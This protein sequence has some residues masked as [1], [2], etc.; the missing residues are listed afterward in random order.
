MTRRTASI[1]GFPVYLRIL[2]LVLTLAWLPAGAQ[3]LAMDPGFAT[4]V[5]PAN[6]TRSIVS[7]PDYTGPASGYHAYGPTAGTF[8]SSGNLYFMDHGTIH[9]IAS[10]ND[11]IPVLSNSGQPNYVASPVA[12]YIYEVGG[13]GTNDPTVGAGCTVTGNAIGN[14]CYATLAW[15]GNGPGAL[16]VDSRGNVFVA[17]QDDTEIRVIYA[18]GTIPNLPANPIV[19]M[20]YAIAGNGTTGNAGDAGPGLSAELKEPV[21]LTLDTSNNVYIA[22]AAANAIRVLY[23]GQGNVIGLPSSPQAGYL[24]TIVGQLGSGCTNSGANGPDDCG[25]YGPANQALLSDPQ[26]VHLDPSGNLYISD[27]EDHRLRAVY[28]GGNLP[29]VSNP[30]AGSIYTVA[31]T[32]SY[33]S[34]V[35]VEGS[36]AS[37]TA[38]LPLAVTID[39]AGNIYFAEQSTQTIQRIDANGIINLAMGGAQLNNPSPVFCSGTTDNLGDGCPSSQVFFESMAGV[40]LDP[41]GNLYGNDN[42]G[43]AMHKSSLSATSLNFTESVGFTTSQTMTLYNNGAQPL[44]FSGLTVSPDFAQVPT[45]S[46]DCGGSTM[47]A[48]ATSCTVQIGYTAP[49]AGTNTGTLAIASNATNAASGINTITLTGTAT[50]DTTSTAFTVSTTLAN[51]NQPVTFTATVSGQYGSTVTPTGTVTFLNGTTTLGTAQVGSNGVATLTTSSLAA[52]SYS[53]VYASYGGDS[54]CQPSASYV[55]A[56]TI[57]ATPVPVVT[58][59]ASAPTIG[60]GAAL[61]LTATVAAYTGSTV[62]TGTVTFQDG[63]AVLGSVTLNGGSAAFS[64]SSLPVGANTLYASYSGNSAFAAALSTGV[65]V[66]VTSGAPQAMLTPGIISTVGG[67]IFAGSVNADNN[68]NIYYYNSSNNA[69]LYVIASGKGIIPGVSNPIAGTTYL[70]ALSSCTNSSSNPC[71]V[72]GPAVNAGIG[73]VYDVTADAAS[74]LYILS[75]DGIFRIDA[76]T[77]NITVINPTPTPA[78]GNAPTS[79]PA[80]SD[81]L[82]YLYADNGGDL[83]I[84]DYNNADIVRVDAITGVMTV[85]AGIPGSYC[86]SLTTACGDGGPA[87]SA[88]LFFA[89]SLYMD[90]SGNLYMLDLNAVRKIDA[91]TGIIHTIAGTFGIACY[92]GNCG[93]G[94]P[95]TQ[96]LFN[97]P[98]GIVGD[99]GGN[100]YIADQQDW[101]VRKIDPQGNISTIAGTILQQGN[102]GDNG[103]A[104]SADLYYPYLIA[105]DAQ[106]NLYIQES[107]DGYLREV[108]GAATAFNYTA[109]AAGPAYT[110]TVTVTNTTGAPLH[111]TGLTIP[112]SLSDFVQQPSG[113]GNDCTGT[114]TLAPGGFCQIGLAFFPQEGGAVTGSLNIADDSSNATGGSNVISLSGT[115]PTGNQSNQITFGSLPDLTYGTKPIT[116]SATATSGQPVTFS[117]AGPATLANNTLIINGAGKITVT[118]YQFG[119]ETYAPAQSIPQ[120]FTVAQ[121]PLTVTANSF[122]CQAGQIAACLTA[123]PLSYQVTGF[124]NGDT[125]TVVSGTAALATTVTA[126]SAAGSYPVTFT[127]QELTAQNYSFTYVPGSVTVTGGEAQNIT[128]GSLSNVTYGAAT[129]ALNA[130]ATSG[131]QPVYTVTGPAVVAGSI[132]TVTGAGVVTVTAEQPGNGT[133][134]AA[135]P[136]SQSFVVNKAMLTVTANDQTMAKGTTPGNFTYTITGLVNGDPSSVVSGAPAFTTNAGPSSALGPQTLYVAQGTLAAANYN[137]NFVNG[138]ITVVA[139]TAQTITFTPVPTLTYGVGPVSLKASSTSGLPVSFTVTGPATLTGSSLN[140]TG[141]GAVTVT[142]TQQGQGAYAAAVPVAQTITVA[143]AVLTVTANNVS[144]PT[145]VMN[146]AFTATITG[147]VN[148]DNSSVVGGFPLFATTAVPGSPAG[149]YPITVAQGILGAVN[150]TFTLAPGTLTVTGGGPVPDFAI[151]ANPQ[152]LTILPGQTGQTTLTLTPVNYFQ[153]SVSV[154]C[155][156][157]PANM[158]CIFTPSAFSVDGTGMPA[159]ITLTVNTNAGAQLVGAL[160]PGGNSR[161]LQAA[162]F[163]LPGGLT[164]LLIAFNRRRFGKHTRVLYGLVFLVLFCGMA[165]S[166]TGCGGGSL[167][168]HSQYAASG[169]S[170]VTLTGVGTSTNL[171]GTESHAVNL[172]VTVEGLQ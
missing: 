37:Q 108:T 77:D 114:E 110:Q 111:I 84:S 68:G 123:N 125:Q 128:F 21:A 130:T 40:F 35:I 152:V 47:L 23:S 151:S 83:Y 56:L 89:P 76:R 113:S 42:Q 140:I 170:T 91:K 4:A 36:Q 78:V 70:V 10:G 133:Y 159:T 157:L 120:S 155:G 62:P 85:V 160:V 138:V 71:N 88:A 93:D 167:T 124:V 58:L 86:S 135:A 60:Q 32:S 145:N 90:A 106:G 3:Q 52:G 150:Y 75:T 34:S 112:S 156:T 132:L 16:S 96:A 154:S 27:T 22:D 18:K 20:I 39:A 158:S 61:T 105:F 67:G 164:G 54:N 26:G 92:S 5:I 99:A 7:K 64:V 121:A 44:Q 2:L 126:G 148:G 169:T 104:T 1:T 11:P 6:T 116:L 171:T 87:T 55:H 95:A 41:A 102:S 162:I 14:G 49:T 103:L 15:I 107:N 19:G 161:L 50:Q 8:D 25:D 33:P 59:T 142:A 127:T 65:S 166:L 163:W 109:A 119:N 29:G 141:A 24:Y 129:V 31:G 48:P 57:S 69:G 74:N 82:T 144:R 13:T 98:G 72:P 30:E 172:T 73:G 38:V 79:A 51:V 17:D 9:V 137:F 165:G 115:A 80:L 45:G 43:V 97:F 94:G 66:Q 118:A 63:S 139:G 46:S 149:T 153:G 53:S 81:S 134:A 146:P 147:F 12:D 143:P 117:V 131:L 28:A 168:A 101:A 100:L 136:V 122:S